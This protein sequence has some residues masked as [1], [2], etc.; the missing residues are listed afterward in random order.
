MN[1]E[2]A[3]S[4]HALEFLESVQW[5]FTRSCH[6]LQQLRAFFLVETTYCT[7]EPLDL[8]RRC[9]VVLILG[10]VLPVV[11]IDVREARDEKLEFLF[12]EDGDELGRND[13][14]EAYTIVSTVLE[15]RNL[16]NGKLTC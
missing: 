4:I 11:D 8:R 1:I 9:G 2:L 5:H 15:S 10:V 16:E 13:I 12:V 3:E 14:M 6:E 7:P